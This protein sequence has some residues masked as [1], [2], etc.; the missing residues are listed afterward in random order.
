MPAIAALT[1]AVPAP[2][3]TYSSYGWRYR[4]RSGEWVRTEMSTGRGETSVS[5]RAQGSSP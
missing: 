5:S 1:T 2:P 3:R 4:T